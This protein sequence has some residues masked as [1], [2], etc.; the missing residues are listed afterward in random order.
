MGI[1]NHFL[2]RKLMENYIFKANQII[3]GKYFGYFSDK[4]LLPFKDGDTVIIP[5]G[6]RYHSMKDGQWHIAGKS[7]KVKINHILCGCQYMERGEFIITNPE[8]S[9]AGSGGYWHR[10]DI[11]DVKAI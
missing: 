11:N 4:S 9:W 3:D 10:A 1:H 7:Y 8:V 5:K 2:E 6:T